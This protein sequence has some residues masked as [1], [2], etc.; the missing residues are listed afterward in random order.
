MVPLSSFQV[1]KNSSPKNGFNGFFSEPLYR[2]GQHPLT[3]APMY[4]QRNFLTA[5][6][7]W[8]Y[9]AVSAWIGTTSAPAGHASARPSPSPAQQISLGVPPVPI[10][11][12]IVSPP[13][14]PSKLTGSH[15]PSSSRREGRES[16][17]PVARILRQASRAQNEWLHTPHR[18]SSASSSSPSSRELYRSRQ[19]RQIARE[20]RN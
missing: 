18:L 20:A 9:T 7:S 5:F 3:P 8:S 13:H 11:H 17:Y 10:P 2:K 12:I 14:G 19:A 6:R 1:P 15:R 4:H 16:S